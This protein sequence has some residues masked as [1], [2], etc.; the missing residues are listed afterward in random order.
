MTIAKI[1]FAALVCVPLVALAG[2]VFNKLADDVTK[3]KQ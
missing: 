2:W 3:K 1:L